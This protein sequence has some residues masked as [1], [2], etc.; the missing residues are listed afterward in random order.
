MT[1]GVVSVDECDAVRVEFR[2]Y[3]NL[4]YHPLRTVMY[5]HG[6]VRVKLNDVVELGMPDGVT[7]MMVSL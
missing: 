7:E 5:S 4:L 2:W 6:S 3:L 1:G